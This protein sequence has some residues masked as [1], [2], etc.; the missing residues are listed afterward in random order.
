M[1][2]QPKFTDFFPRYDT[3][4]PRLIEAILNS[5]VGRSSPRR[6]VGPLV[7]QERSTLCNSPQPLPV[8]S[9]FISL[10]TG[11]HRTTVNAMSRCSRANAATTGGRCDR[12]RLS[13]PPHG[14]RSAAK[15]I[16]EAPTLIRSGNATLI[17]GGSL[18][19]IFAYRGIGK[20]ALAA[21]FAGILL[22][23]GEFLGFSKSD[24]GHR[25][26]LVDGELPEVDLQSRI[27]TFTKPGDRGELR[28]R[29]EGMGDDGVTYRRS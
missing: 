6:H 7:S 14:A 12:R 8:R 9:T 16:P 3:D 15:Q 11:V 28:L 13:S 17:R 18:N 19:E 23:G 1:S 26:L 22:N 27:N 21:S 20:S 25:V 29:Y 24:G 4:E 5:P 10:R 2:T